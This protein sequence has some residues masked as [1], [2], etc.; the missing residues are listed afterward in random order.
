MDQAIVLEKQ[1]KEW[2]RGWKL[3]LIEA[4]NPQWDDLFSTLF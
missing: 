2:R 3:K 4:G 1:L